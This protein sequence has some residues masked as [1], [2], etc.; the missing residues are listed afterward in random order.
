MRRI[1]R[2][3]NSASRSAKPRRR[4]VGIDASLTSTGFAYRLDG[5]VRTGRVDTGKLR[6]SHRL[7]YIRERAREVIQAS[8]AE[9]VVLEDYAFSRGPKSGRVFNI[10]EGGGVLKLLFWEMGVDVIIVS[11]TCLKRSITG[12]GRL[13]K[14]AAGKTEMMKAIQQLLGYDIRQSDEADALGLMA[15][16]EAYLDQAGPALLLQRVRS[17]EPPTIEMGGKL[18]R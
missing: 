11:S 9:V 8:R 16:G 10:G 4:I 18:K 12:K 17:G 15:Y 1:V 5:E 6:G 14:G 13:S 3:A 7:Y 2:S